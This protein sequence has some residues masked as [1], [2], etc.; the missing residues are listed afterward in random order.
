ME[1]DIDAWK[2]PGNPKLT[3]L[4]SLHTCFLARE[5]TK[6]FHLRITKPLRLG[7]PSQSFEGNHW[8]SINPSPKMGEWDTA[9]P[10]RTPEPNWLWLFPPVQE[11]RC[12]MLDWSIIPPFQVYSCWSFALGKEH[13]ARSSWM[14]LLTKL[15]KKKRD[16]IFYKVFSWSLS[17]TQTMDKLK[18]AV[19]SQ[20]KLT[21]LLPPVCYCQHSSNQNFSAHPQNQ[22]CCLCF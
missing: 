17:T 5:K 4:L 16:W 3:S 22:T 8:H 2:I 11:W 9:N 10:G 19:K 1:K 15:E 21:N 13:I 18:Q 20:R 7:K 12:S 14:F 6:V